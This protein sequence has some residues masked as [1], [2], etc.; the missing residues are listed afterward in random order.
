M[1]SARA[2]V[3]CGPHNT[4]EE[5]HAGQHGIWAQA[6]APDA[7]SPMRPRDFDPFGPLNCPAG[8]IDG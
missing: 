4:H 2:A 5:N 8:K 7:R 3:R 6:F 1:L